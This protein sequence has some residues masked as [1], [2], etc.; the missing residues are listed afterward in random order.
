MGA[1]AVLTGFEGAEKRLEVDFYVTAHHARGAPPGPPRLPR[2]PRRPGLAPPAA[3]ALHYPITPPEFLPPGLREL[4]RDQ[5]DEYLTAAACTIVSEQ[6]APAFDAYVLSES[7]LFVYATK[8]VIK[9][10]GTTSLLVATPTLLRL[11]AGLRMAPRAVK[12][13]RACFK[14]PELQPFPHRSWAEEAAYLDT[15]FGKL[16]DGAT[17]AVLVRA[18]PRRAARAA[19][20]CANVLSPPLAH[21]LPARARVDALATRPPAGRILDRPAVAHVH[22]RGEHAARAAL[23]RLLPRAA[24][25]Q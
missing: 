24:R 16:G 17:T 20:E 13:T 18:A 3:R 23:A 14:Y 22:G 5:L 25:Q 4:T 10:C 2:R 7:S 6:H 15:L 1:P 21:S 8:V 9:T 19:P 11:A 12:Y